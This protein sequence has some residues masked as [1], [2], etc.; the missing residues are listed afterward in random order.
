ML[1]SWLRRGLRLRRRRSRAA[2]LLLMT[3]MG[4]LLDQE[5]L[6]LVSGSLRIVVV[7]HIV[8]APDSRV[9]G[10]GSFGVP[11]NLT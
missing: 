7:C 6:L 4:R 11:S 2:I 9:V 5:L 10:F 1:E 3:V 8:I